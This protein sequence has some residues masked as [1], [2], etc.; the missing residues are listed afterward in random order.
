MSTSVRFTRS[1]TF[2]AGVISLLVAIPAGA[3]RR[4]ARTGVAAPAPR[5]VG[6]I[7]VAA[8][9]QSRIVPGTTGGVLNSRR[10]VDPTMNRRISNRFNNRFNSRFQ[11]PLQQRRI[12]PGFIGSSSSCRMTATMTA[13]TARCGLRRQWSPAVARDYEE[14]QSLAAFGDLQRR[15]RLHPGP[16]R[17]AL[18]DHRRGADGGRL[19]ERR[20][21]CF[22]VV[23]RSRA[24]C[25]IRRAGRARSS[26]TRR[27]TG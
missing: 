3:Q 15:P 6:R 11:Q 27:T 19:R 22:P 20:A 23:R 9:P 17:L 12:D 7:G 26:I 25:A 14:M 21:T 5:S 24:T 4:P 8:P 13:T 2:V 16:H 10:F 18:R 1:A